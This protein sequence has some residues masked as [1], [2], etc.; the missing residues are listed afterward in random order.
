MF[1]RSLSCAS[2]TNTLT[3]SLSFTDLG[4]CRISLEEKELTL[5]CFVCV[6]LG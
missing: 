1:A 2:L 5:N 6:T 3:I 4:T